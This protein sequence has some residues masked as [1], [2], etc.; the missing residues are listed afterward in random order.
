MCSF[1]CSK[2][3]KKTNDKCYTLAVEDGLNV[4]LC[5]P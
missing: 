4:V 1:K 3:D 5:A 2:E